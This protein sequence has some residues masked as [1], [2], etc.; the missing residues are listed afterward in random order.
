M[1]YK[2]LIDKRNN[3][4]CFYQTILLSDTYQDDP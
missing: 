4:L 2:A 3:L 1:Y